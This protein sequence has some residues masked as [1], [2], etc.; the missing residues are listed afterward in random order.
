MEVGH[1]TPLQMEARLC[2]WEHLLECRN[3]FQEGIRDDQD[4]FNAFWSRKGTVEMRLT[5]TA[6]IADFCLQV[7]DAEEGLIKSRMEAVGWSYDWDFIPFVVNALI[8]VEGSLD[9]PFDL[10]TVVSRVLR[11]T[12][13]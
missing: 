1:I 3:R 4:A 7:F 12:T 13:L 2:V 11:S 9:T 5:V 10:K 6:Q 8:Y